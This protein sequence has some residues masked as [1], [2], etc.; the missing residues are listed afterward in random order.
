MDE[1]FA[2]AVDFPHA[3]F[4]RGEANLNTFRGIL[5]ITQ[6]LTK[7]EGLVVPVVPS[8]HGVSAFAYLPEGPAKRVANISV[9]CAT[10]MDF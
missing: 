9:L 4:L 2:N 6:L 7:I 8:T 1:V 10:E 3:L 5:A